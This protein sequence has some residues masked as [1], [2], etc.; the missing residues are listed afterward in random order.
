MLIYQS[1]IT[2]FQKSENGN[3]EWEMHENSGFHQ[4]FH[5]FPKNVIKSVQNLKTSKENEFQKSENH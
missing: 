5:F 2:F 4:H 1:N 3:K